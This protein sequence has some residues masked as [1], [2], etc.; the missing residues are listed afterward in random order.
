MYIYIYIYT[1]NRTLLHLCVPALAGAAIPFFCQRRSTAYWKMLV[2]RT[3]YI[4]TYTQG[5]QQF[6]PYSIMAKIPPSPL[7]IL[8]GRLS[9]VSG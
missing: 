1:H 8:T 5:G 4:C 9:H 6:A 7:R 3:Y 2:P